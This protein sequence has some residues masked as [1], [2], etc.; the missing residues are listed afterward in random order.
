MSATPPACWIAAAST[1]TKSYEYMRVVGRLDDLRA[2]GRLHADE[3]H[4]EAVLE[5]RWKVRNGPAPTSAVGRPDAK[6]SPST[7]SGW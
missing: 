4:A 6:V 7:Q 5:S 2:V 3:L 1:F